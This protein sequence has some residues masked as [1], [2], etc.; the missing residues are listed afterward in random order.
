VGI[1]FESLQRVNWAAVGSSGGG[2]LETVP[3]IVT[4]AKGY[5]NFT[6]IKMHCPLPWLQPLVTL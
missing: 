6:A 4:L 5:P 1:A 3:D 2:G